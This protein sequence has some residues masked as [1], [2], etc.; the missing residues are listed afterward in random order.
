[1]TV[2]LILEDDTNCYAVTYRRLGELHS[3][4]KD[5]K[6]QIVKTYTNDKE[7]ELRDELYVKG[8]DWNKLKGLA[9]KVGIKISQKEPQTAK[10]RAEEAKPVFEAYAKEVARNIFVGDPTLGKGSDSQFERW[11]K[12]LRPSTY[13]L[14]EKDPKYISDRQKRK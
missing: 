11:F 4:K 2:C 10:Q 12:G 13:K 5:S 9:E 14:K 1:M 7:Q 3:V 6:G 8:I